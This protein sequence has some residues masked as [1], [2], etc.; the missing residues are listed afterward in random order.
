MLSSLIS[1]LFFLVETPNPGGGPPPPPPEPPALYLYERSSPE[2]GAM[3]VGETRINNPK[4]QP[5][6]L[7]YEPDLIDLV[8][9]C[10]YYAE[11][12]LQG[13][14]IEDAA[15][16]RRVVIVREGQKETLRTMLGPG[17]G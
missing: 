16:Q 2:K 6:K 4:Q 17:P 13:R 3:V 9:C 1:L 7:C 11:L 8:N 12:R 5:R 10:S 15:C 14:R